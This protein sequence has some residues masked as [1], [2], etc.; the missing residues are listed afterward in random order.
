MRESGCPS[1]GKPAGAPVINPWFPFCC[2]TC[3]MIDLSNW[4]DNRY[5]VVSKAP[6]DEEESILLIDDS[7]PSE[8]SKPYS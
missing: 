5:V 4:L 1:C 3:K 7:D 6:F 2:Q 8:D